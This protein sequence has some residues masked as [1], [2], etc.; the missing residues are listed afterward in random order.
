MCDDLAYKKKNLFTEHK[1][2][3]I[4]ILDRKT[5]FYDRHKDFDSD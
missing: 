1:L 3:K 2:R 5:F 4:S